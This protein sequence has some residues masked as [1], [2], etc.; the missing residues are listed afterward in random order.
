M[1]LTAAQ[2]VVLRRPAL[3]GD[4][5]M[6]SMLELAALSLS[7]TVFGTDHYQVALALLVLHL[8]AK[9][10]RGGG[11]APGA[12]TSETE[13]G[14]SRSYSGPVGAAGMTAH[15]WE[16][17]TWGQELLALTRTITMGACISVQEE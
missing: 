2:I 16:S 11:G 13:G 3:T 14:L 9:D 10:D 1:A 6:T 17:T 15:D 12:I 4:L 5:R 7:E 8:Y